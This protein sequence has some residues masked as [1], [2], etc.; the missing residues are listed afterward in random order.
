MPV[1][2]ASPSLLAIETATELCSV[3]VHCA[4]QIWHVS[5]H[6]GQQHSEML[7][8]MVRDVLSQANMTLADL[9]AIAFGAGPGSFTGLRIACGVVQGLAFAQR[10]PVLPIPSLEALAQ[11]GSGQVLCAVDARMGEVYAAHYAV[12]PDGVI[13]CVRAAQVLKP[14]ALL[15][16]MAAQ[17]FITL[18]GNAWKIFPVLSDWGRGHAQKII[19]D[20][21]PDARQILQ[22]ALVH[23]AA[24]LAV[25]AELAHPLYVRQRIALTTAEREAGQRL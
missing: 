9:D 6:A 25:S 21:Y 15:D 3:A 10:I 18:I 14:E 20:V 23:W 16:Q 17:N 24:G 1:H 19:A 4:N 13:E 7:L 5:A 8:P 11:V 2:H 22:R 12:S